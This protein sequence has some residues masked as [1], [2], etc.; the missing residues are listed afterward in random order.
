MKLTKE[1]EQGIRDIAKKYN[2]DED[3]AVELFYTLEARK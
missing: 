1:Q 3:E 2:Q